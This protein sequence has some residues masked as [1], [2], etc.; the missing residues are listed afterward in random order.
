LQDSQKAA[1]IFS[2][3]GVPGTF[4]FSLANVDTVGGPDVIVSLCWSDRQN[5]SGVA[6][7]VEAN[8]AAA[9]KGTHG[10]L[11]P[12]DLHNTL[13]AMGPDFRRGLRSQVPSGN[14]DV[15]AT[16]LHLLGMAPA[17]SLD[18]RV[19]IESLRGGEDPPPSKTEVLKAS[20]ENWQ[21]HLRLTKIG[22]VGYFE[23]GGAGPAPEP[24]FERK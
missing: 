5:Q 6:G 7:M 16:I 8:G 20:T 21:Q 22:D 3:D 15:P 11:S 23:E 2:R 17:Q 14:L 18:G 9:A 24:D 1:V 4:P 13:V 12:F 19:L 10:A